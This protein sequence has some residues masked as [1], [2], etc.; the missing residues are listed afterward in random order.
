MAN[1]N[2]VEVLNESWGGQGIFFESGPGGL[3]VVVLQ[4]GDGA[5]AKVALHGAHVLGYTPA[6]EKPVL[7]MSREAVFAEGKPIRGGIPVCWP[8]FANHP[9]EP[10]FPAHGFA[11]TRAWDLLETGAAEDGRGPR[12]VLGTATPPEDD[13]WFPQAF[14]LRYAV[15]LADSLQVAFSVT[16]TADVAFTFTGALHSYFNVS[17]IASVKIEGLGGRAYI[18][19][20]DG[21]KCKV[22]EG[23]IRIAEE[24]DRIYV[25]TEDDCIVA[26]EGWGRRIRVAKRGSRSTVVWNPWVAK[27][28]RMAD[29]GDDEFQGMVCVETAFAADDAVTLEPGATHTVSLKIDVA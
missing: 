25:D 28:K 2:R 21:R 3:P 29:F 27:S 12:V 10:D 18:D 15:T 5:S 4:A 22:Q 23:A 9:T 11:R 8:W 17:A 13:R 20:T 1:E 24:V 26:D 16:N 19:S 7:W 6:G 14:G